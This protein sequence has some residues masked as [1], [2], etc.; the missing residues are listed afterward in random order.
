MA[1]FIFLSCN[2][3]H[4]KGETKRLNNLPSNFVESFYKDWLDNINFFQDIDF[5]QQ[6]VNNTSSKDVKRYLLGTSEFGEEIQGKIDLCVANNRLNKT[7][8]RRKLD[9]ISKNII[10]N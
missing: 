5:Q 10:K 8:F 3:I 7:S 2:R 6:L 4:K 1:G 9:P